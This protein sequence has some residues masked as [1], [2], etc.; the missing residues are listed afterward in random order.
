[1]QGEP[2]D[3][4][5]LRADF[6]RGIAALEEFA[7]TYDIL[8]YPRHLPVAAEFVRRFPRQRFVLDHLQSRL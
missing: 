4:F 3:R 7:P 1:M 8:I 2:D 5:L 6:L